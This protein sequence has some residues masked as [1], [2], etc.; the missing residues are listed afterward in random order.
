MTTVRHVHSILV[1]GAAGFVGSNFVHYWRT[2]YP[3]TKL[4]ALDALTYAGSMAN[5]QRW[6][7]SDKCVFCHGDILDTGLVERL[8]RAHQVDTIVNFAAETHVDRSIVADDV[9]VQSNLVGTHSLLKAARAVWL[10]DGIPSPNQYR[11]HQVSTDE[12]YGS[13]D[14]AGPA[15]TENTCYSPN[16]P[17]AASKA[18]AD[19]LVCAYHATFGL[20]TTISHCSNNF[21]PYQLPEK[22]VPLMIVNA[23]RGHPL[24]VYGDGLNVRDWLHVTDHV[25]GI[26]LCLRRG[27]SGARYNFGGNAE[28]TNL[29][30][31]ET[32]CSQLDHHFERESALARRFPNAPPAAGR[33]SR[34]LLQFV[35][36]RP[37]HDRRYAMNTGKVEEE[38]GY[39]VSTDFEHGVGMTVDWYLENT[40]WW[41]TWNVDR[42]DDHPPLS[43]T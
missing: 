30:V 16:S 38:L 12:V 37:G 9:F 41:D 10:G 43:P 29:D 13:L 7:G 17:Y 14:S 21:G 4:V 1:T 15:F 35:G 42:S 19:H 28:R 18:G 32:V 22:L 25:R 33:A 24:T 5:I 11:F 6:I 23:L 27:S 39:T 40:D 20:N 34:S 3:D 8:I 31:I 2:H 36:D 26:D